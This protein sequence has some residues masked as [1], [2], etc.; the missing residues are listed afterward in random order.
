[1]VPVNVGQDIQS[2]Q[3]SLDAAWA[4]VYRETEWRFCISEK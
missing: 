2:D 1:M 3:Y 4:M